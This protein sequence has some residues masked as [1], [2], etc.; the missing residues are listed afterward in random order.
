MPDVKQVPLARMQTVQTGT[1]LRIDGGHGMAHRLSS[2]G[3]IPGKRITKIS[4]MMMH[5]PVMIEV[6]RAQV[7][8]GFGMARHILVQL[9]GSA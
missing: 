6:D 3:I 2:L 4:S 8:L 9:P 1:V 7:A 5:G